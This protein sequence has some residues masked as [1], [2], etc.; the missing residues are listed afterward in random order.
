M[1]RGTTTK[2]Q[3]ASGTRFRGAV[4][5]SGPTAKV[6][7]TFLVGKF[8][9]PTIASTS[10]RCRAPQASTSAAVSLQNRTVALPLDYSRRV[11]ATSR[12]LALSVAEGS[13]ITSLPR[14]QSKGHQ[15]QITPFLIYGTGI[16]NF[17]NCLKIKEKTFSN[18]R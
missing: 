11:P 1:R 3:D 12:R 16:N 18:I 9:Q 17:S 10:A 2:R 4:R 5:R 8:V 6:D 14:A 15:S 13:R 7:R